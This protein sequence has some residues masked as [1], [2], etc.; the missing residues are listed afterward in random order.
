M[1]MP[2]PLPAGGISV[3]SFRPYPSLAERAT[4]PLVDVLDLDS[5]PLRD[6]TPPAI[7]NPK[8]HSASAALAAV[9]LFAILGGLAYWNY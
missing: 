1:R 8:T 6:A 4:T 2:L 9:L 3:S 7:S 5:L